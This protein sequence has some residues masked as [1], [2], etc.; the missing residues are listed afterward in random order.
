MEYKL[1]SILRS[2]RGKAYFLN[3]EHALFS[4][5]DIRSRHPDSVI[6]TIMLSGVM[7]SYVEGSAS[8]MGICGQTV[9][10]GLK[11]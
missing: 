9:R 6:R 3:V 11:G 7:N 1:S 2:G 5:L 10:N 4:A 8:S